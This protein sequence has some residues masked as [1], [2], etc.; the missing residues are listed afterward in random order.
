MKASLIETIERELVAAPPVQKRKMLAKLARLLKI[1]PNDIS[2]LK[3]SEPSFE[4]WDNPEDA[5]YDQL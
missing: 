3:L 2:W 4:F 5:I 1:S